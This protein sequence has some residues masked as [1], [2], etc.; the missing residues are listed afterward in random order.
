MLSGALDYTGYKEFTAARVAL[1]AG[2]DL[3]E[4]AGTRIVRNGGFFSGHVFRHLTN[5]TRLAGAA[6]AGF[7]SFW[8]GIQD[9]AITATV[10]LE[11]LPLIGTGYLGYRAARTCLGSGG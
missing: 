9:R 7:G 10:P 5:G 11:V 6:S 3:L 4:R 2:S 8:Q 1:G